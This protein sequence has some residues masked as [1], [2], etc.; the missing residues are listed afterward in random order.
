MRSMRSTETEPRD[1]SKELSHLGTRDASRTYMTLGRRILIVDDDED[2]RSLMCEGLRRRGLN[3]DMADSAQACLKRIDEVA[4][5]VV[6]TDVEMPG[7]SGIELC[8][9]LT[10]R[11]PP[12]VTVVVTNRPSAMTAALASGAFAF[13]AKPFGLDALEATIRRACAIA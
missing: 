6:V 5:D 9:L 10:R 4:F 2:L 7:M 8:R 12:L 1:A 3:A 13:L 11:T